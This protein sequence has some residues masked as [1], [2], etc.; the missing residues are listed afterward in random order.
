MADD[1]LDKS[2]TESDSDAGEEKPIVLLDSDN[3]GKPRPDLW[4]HGADDFSKLEVAADGIWQQIGPA[5]LS[6][7]DYTMSQ[8]M[9]QNGLS[10]EVT[11]I[12]IDPSGATD[13]F[14]YLSTG[15]GGVWMSSD[16]GNHWIPVTDNL[17][18]LAIGT[19]AIDPANPTT[20]YAGT[21][22]PVEVEAGEYGAPRGVGIYKSV[23]HGASWFITDGGPFAT[24]MAGFA[25]TKIVVP[26]KDVV[27]VGTNHGLFRSIDG[28]QNFGANSTFDDGQP[29]P[30]D[31][32]TD[33][34]IS[35]LVM[36]S[37]TA[38][39][40]Y[41]CVSG[42]GVYVSSDSGATFPANSNLFSKSGAP[43][44]FYRDISLAERNGTIFVS[45]AGVNPLTKEQDYVG[46]YMLAAD[47]WISCPDSKRVEKMDSVGGE[48]TNYDLTVGID[49]QD[50]SNQR[51][52]LGFQR[53]WVAQ[54][55][56]GAVSFG[57]GPCVGIPDAPNDDPNGLKHS[58]VHADHHAIAFSP[59]AHTSP[60]VYVGTDGGIFKSSDGTHWS[61]MN[62]GIAT[63]Q[64]YSFDIGR[65]S[66]PNNAFNYA[67]MQD[68][69]VAC[70]QLHGSNQWGVYF[71]GDGLS[72]AADPT[73]PQVAYS[74][75]QL[76]FVR[77]PNNG[78]AYDASGAKSPAVGKSLPSRQS[79]RRCIAVGLNGTDT[80]KR[81]I[82]V[83]IDNQLFGSSNGGVDFKRLKWFVLSDYI[84]V[85]AVSP[86][87]PNRLW[88]GMEDG[89]VHMSADG[90]VSWDA[91]SFT[92]S[93]GG[94]GVVSAIALDSNPP[95]ANPVDA[96]AKDRVVVAYSQFTEINPT[97]R[98]RHLYRTT[99]NGNTWTDI[100]GTDGSGP[101]GNLP[102]LPIQS[103]VI[104]PTTNPSTLIVGT[105]CGVVRSKDNGAS[106]Q[107]L[108]LGL[109]GVRCTGLALD[110][111]TNGLRVGT[112]GRSCFEF[113]KPS[114][115]FLA[116]DNRFSF[117]PVALN[118]TRTL[119][120]TI[121]N[122]GN[123]DFD[124]TAISQ[125][126]DAEISFSAAFTGNI[127]VAANSS[128]DLTVQFQPTAARS[129][130]AQLQ[131][132]TTDT[133]HSPFV[134]Y[135]SGAGVATG[136]PRLSANANLR[137]GTV[138][139][140]NTRTLEAALSNAGSADLIISGIS[141][142]DD[143]KFKLSGLPT[144]PVT[145][146]PGDT[147][148]FSCTYTPTG[149]GADET[150][151]VVSSNDPRQQTTVPING[152]GEGFTRW[153]LVIGLI[154][155]GVAATAGGVALAI[156]ESKKK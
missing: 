20:I 134:V 42:K 48:Q 82:Y 156:A 83:S 40:V 146:H 1:D 109:P 36:D 150:K 34:A 94:S 70:S 89:S 108:G 139:K 99:D 5:P 95:N 17:P 60:Q 15:D 62:A 126:G 57:A 33:L 77:T 75:D 122:I 8:W 137:F 91:G 59:A 45:V 31:G 135:T 39:K 121:Y 11:G 114:G 148:K 115:K 133:A 26:Q 71:S 136:S 30:I 41:A 80:S 47:R 3:K 151:I 76:N 103:A 78:A 125:S 24:C 23:D 97:Y 129:Y 86:E 145:L 123:Q 66:V 153:I 64:L 113:V 117:G 29:L 43:T 54:T 93:P 21:G 18:S 100:S 152:T 74:L 90:G 72:I 116:S 51:V 120:F 68:N 104:D 13:T 81:Q 154:A 124:I 143:D 4:R 127:T 38:G 131:L 87:D 35:D 101:A 141:N 61:S 130:S 44:F 10:G 107:R 27:L 84:S 155:L 32:H 14:L 19:I 140:S 65:G 55:P 49:P 106:W 37:R 28:G 25:V 138:S 16:G 98:T 46:L 22:N 85:V 92:T 111:V 132:T 12:A 56:G 50:A 118:A 128:K 119:K 58:Q 147:Q 112:Y 53:L 88:V 105:G 96:H 102:D 149:N 52:F 73:D 9:G 6:E 63:A 7:T 69:S 79:F 110:A 67:A 144:F 2:R 142:P